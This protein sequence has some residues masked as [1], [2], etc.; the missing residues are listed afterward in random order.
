MDSC[1]V[2][3]LRLILN[4]L[5]IFAVFEWTCSHANG[6][7]CVYFLLNQ[8]LANVKVLSRK[9]LMDKEDIHAY[10]S[11][12]GLCLFWVLLY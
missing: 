7:N 5:I 6:C 4:V 10:C 2:A 3:S 8:L 1:A 12:V 11:G 9:A